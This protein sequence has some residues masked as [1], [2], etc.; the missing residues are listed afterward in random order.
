MAVKWKFFPR[1]TLA[2]LSCLSAGV[3]SFYG[4]QAIAG[5]QNASEPVIRLSQVDGPMVAPLQHK[6]AA[7]ILLLFVRTD[8][9]ISNRYAP[10]LQQLYERF[11]PKNIDFWLVYPDPD[12]SADAILKHRKDFRLTIPALRD[13][14]HL[15]VRKAE[16]RVTPEAAVFLPN[17]EEIYRGRID[18]QYVDFGQ[19]RPAPTRS[20]L[21]NV[22]ARLSDGK[23][24]TRTVNT[25]VG[26][27]ISGLP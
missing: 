13:P 10:L 19:Q 23:P 11:N 7:G 25:A 21:E 3:I 22:L 26:C 14:N 2:G 18:D 15:L 6:S 16:V 27:Y 4:S 24:L 20:D 12:E 8:C 1:L 17:G 9:P 5:E